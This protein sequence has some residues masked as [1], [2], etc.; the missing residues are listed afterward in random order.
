MAFFYCF[1]I[2]LSY[3][4]KYYSVNGLVHQY[5]RHFFVLEHQYGCRD[6]I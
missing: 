1:F 2:D 4:Y 5:D 3:K 6:V